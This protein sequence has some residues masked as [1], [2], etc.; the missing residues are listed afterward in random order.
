MRVGQAGTIRSVKEC[1]KD[2]VVV[3]Y[4]GIGFQAAGSR[5]KDDR[6]KAYPTRSE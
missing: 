4:R 3:I 1:A 6:L 2:E 5:T